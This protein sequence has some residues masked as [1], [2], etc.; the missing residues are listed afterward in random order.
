MK[1]K[2]GLITELSF[3]RFVWRDTLTEKGEGFEIPEFHDAV[4]KNGAVP[5]QVL[6][7]M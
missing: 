2:K 4:L 1:Y 5:V 3:E 7:L 6:D